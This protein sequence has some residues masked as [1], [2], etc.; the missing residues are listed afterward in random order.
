MIGR[1]LLRALVVSA[2]VLVCEPTSGNAQST[3]ERSARATVD[4]FFT[5]VARERWD[6]AATL[7]D[8]ARFEPYFK[9]FVRNARSAIPQRPMTVE[10]LMASDSTMPRAVAEWE[11]GRMNRGGARDP[12]DYLSMQF[13]GITTPRDLFA[14]TTS[15]AAARWL[16]AQDERTLM[17]AAWRRSGCPLS[18]VRDFPSSHDT[19]LGVV[20]S[21]DSLAYVVHTDDRFAAMG[22]ES[23]SPTERVM[24]LRRVNGRWQIEPRESL[25]RRDGAVGYSFECSQT[26]R[27]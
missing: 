1:A 11:I 9:G 13:A 24:R 22:P 6:S 15:A 26:K 3:A 27:P 2:A 23:L 4:S 25:L 20:V 12:F 14:L 8:L 17:R 7:L 16:E 5:L 18:D 10:D 21:G 19:V